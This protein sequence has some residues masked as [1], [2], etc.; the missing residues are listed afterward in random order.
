V[1]LSWL[2]DGRNLT[3]L[4]PM[5]WRGKTDPDAITGDILYA[6]ITRNKTHA[7]I[8]FTSYGLDH[9]GYYDCHA[10]DLETGISDYCRNSKIS[11]F[12]NIFD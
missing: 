2:K 8:H 12:A 3:E 9:D 11:K 10:T 6:N 4:G 1:Q 5:L 7:A